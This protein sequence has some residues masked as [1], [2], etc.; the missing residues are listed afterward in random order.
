MLNSRPLARLTHQTLPD[1]CRIRS[2]LM[3]N[4]TRRRFP[5]AVEAALRQQNGTGTA[6]LAVLSAAPSDLSR[7]ELIA[8]THAYLLAQMPPDH[9]ANSPTLPT[10]DDIAITLLRLVELGIAELIVTRPAPD[11]PGHERRTRQR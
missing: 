6:V 8:A 9:P 2:R 10:E 1:A 4:G 7:D 11:V 3:V 5:A